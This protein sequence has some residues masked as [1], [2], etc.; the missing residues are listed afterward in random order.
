MGLAA[1]LK[2][3][4]RRESRAVAANMGSSDDCVTLPTA[5]VSSCS[6]QVE[7]FINS[8][9]ISIRVEYHV[10]SDHVSGF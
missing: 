7:D 3:S 6:V 1:G 9:R 5:F 2:F 10:V 8:N 4:R